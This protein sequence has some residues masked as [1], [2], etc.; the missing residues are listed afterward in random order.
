MSIWDFLVSFS[1]YLDLSVF[2]PQE[3]YNW[4]AETKEWQNNIISNIF[5]S[6]LRIKFKSKSKLSYEIKAYKS[7][8]YGDQIDLWLTILRIYV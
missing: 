2:T 8:S 7:F 4:L 1:D 3:F 5:R 6:F